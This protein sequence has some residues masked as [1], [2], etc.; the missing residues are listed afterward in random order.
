MLK[1]FYADAPLAA[2]YHSNLLNFGH[3]LDGKSFDETKEIV[4]EKEESVDAANFALANRVGKDAVSPNANS[5]ADGRFGKAIQLTGDDAVEI[6]EVG[7]F[8]RHDPFAFS[9]W[10]WS[11]EVEL[12]VVVIMD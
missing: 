4:N 10:I 12:I 6:P 11:P 1:E 9:L 2:W 3:L 8:A 7:H 5:L